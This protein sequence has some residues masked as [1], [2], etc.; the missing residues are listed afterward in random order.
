[1]AWT[2][3]LTEAALFHTE[4]MRSADLQTH[5]VPAEPGLREEEPGLRD[6]TKNAGYTEQS[7]LGENVFAFVKS[8]LHAHAAYAIDWGNGPNGIQDPPGHRNTIMNPRTARSASACST[9]C[10]ATTP[11]RC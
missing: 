8:M 4:Q 6:R 9:R 2:E 3:D 7:A 11:A 5:R 10:R 1:L